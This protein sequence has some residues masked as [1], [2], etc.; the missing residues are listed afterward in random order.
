MRAGRKGSVSRRT[1]LRAGLAGG[2]ALAGGGPARAGDAPAAPDPLI[3]EVQPWAR[4]LGDPVDAAG[5]GR[6]V[7]FEAGVTRRT[8]DW[9]TPDLHTSVS[10][11]PL[12]ALD[13]TITPNG[14][15][16][17][18]SHAG[19]A[20][21]PKE[22]WR[23]M[24][25]GLVE[26]PLVFTYDD[27]MRFPRVTRTHFLECAANGVMEWNGAQLNGVQFTH[28]MIHNVAYTG[29]LLRD[30]LAEAGVRPGA[31]WLLAEGADGSGMTRSLPLAKALDDCLVAFAMNGEKLRK[32]QGYPA[33]L[34]VPGWEGSL[35]IKW[36]R[37]LELGD[38]PWD[39]R[40]ETSK[41][42]DLMPDGRAR[43]WTWVMD[44]KSVITSPSP[45]A[46]VRHGPGPMVI[47]GLAWSG[48]GRIAQVDVSLD[49]GRSWRPARLDGPGQPMALQRFYLDFRWDGGEM[50]L[51]SRARDETGYV[52]PGKDAL[53]TIRGSGSG[54]HM[55]G[56]QT[57]WVKP[58][59]E[60]ENVEV[61]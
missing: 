48:R 44:A 51:Q 39:Q 52:Q 22:G 25:N 49:G 41:Y 50:L 2:A 57:W 31:A 35:W 30:I 54:Y 3:T 7:R 24:L 32:E 26:R 43:K 61:S 53:R 58:G 9:L 45:E 20:E 21:I 6:P 28:G 34:V 42:T 29:V 12:H 16:F 14:L 11:T 56:I 17:E 4:V 18:R 10:F 38:Q 60:T 36:L 55:N 46:P 1:L 59:G 15:C 19:A 33:R 13:G 23:L 37:R 8:I 5:Y 40:E 47:S 27:L